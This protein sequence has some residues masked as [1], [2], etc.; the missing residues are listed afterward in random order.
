[1]RCHLRHFE[2]GQPSLTGSSHARC[3]ARA[4]QPGLVS[5]QRAQARQHLS[6]LHSQPGGIGVLL[7][8]FFLVGCAP[9]SGAALPPVGRMQGDR[10]G[11][12]RRVLAVREERGRRRATPQ[13]VRCRQRFAK[14]R[15]CPNL[16]RGGL[17][18][19]QQGRERHV[20]REPSSRRRDA[21]ARSAAQRRPPPAPKSERGAAGRVGVRA[22]GAGFTPAERGGL[23]GARRR[24]S[25]GGPPDGW[26]RKQAERDSLPR[27]AGGSGGRGGGGRAGGRRTGGGEE[28]RSGIHSRG[29]RG[30]RGV[31]AAEAGRGA[32]GR[33]AAKEARSGIHSRGARGVRGV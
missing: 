1:M 15:E 21:S 28:A 2:C 9:R 7:L 8:C 3:G 17:H 25:G 23:G 10:A 18:A 11:P 33:A 29:A 22:S 19:V 12:R 31:E 14:R 26:G 6:C 27:S 30:V 16:A 20:R 13:M 4:P 24:R 32:A 5:L